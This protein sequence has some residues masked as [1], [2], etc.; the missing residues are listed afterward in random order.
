M[1]SEGPDEEI[2]SAVEQRTAA[3]WADSH[4]KRARTSAAAEVAYELALADA[5]RRR[6]KQTD[7]LDLDQ[8]QFGTRR[9]RARTACRAAADHP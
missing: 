9:C 5:V 1:A 3:L 6:L 8:P 7:V 2:A 4:R